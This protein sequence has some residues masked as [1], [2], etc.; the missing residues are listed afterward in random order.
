MHGAYAP[1]EERMCTRARC[2]LQRCKWTAAQLLQC[3]QVNAQMARRGHGARPCGQRAGMQLWSVK[4]PSAA[5]TFACASDD[6]CKLQWAGLR[7]APNPMP[8][9]ACSARCSIWHSTRPFSF[10]GST[11]RAQTV[12]AGRYCWRSGSTLAFRPQ[13]THAPLERD[14]EVHHLLRRQRRNLELCCLRKLL[15]ARVAG[16][17]A[18]AEP[19]C[20]EWDV[21]VL[22]LGDGLVN[23]H[24]AACGR[25]ENRGQRQAVVL[26]CCTTA[27]CNVGTPCASPSAVTGGV[28]PP[29]RRA[30][31]VPG[32]P[33]QRRK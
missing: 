4:V 18:S 5:D 20:P 31:G 2:V 8:H 3:V 11:G 26:E 21:H 19:V 28:L 29:P 23:D 24:L 15:E 16:V 13:R 10:S 7:H 17:A 30:S 25:C 12:H 14:S 9:A 1:D 33:S 32:I 27:A 6:A 22:H